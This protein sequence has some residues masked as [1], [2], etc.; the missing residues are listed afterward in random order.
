MRVI[1]LVRENLFLRYVSHRV[2]C[3][4]DQWFVRA[5]GEGA[6]RHV[7]VRLSADEVAASCAEMAA[8]Q[9]SCAAFPP[10]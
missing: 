2:A 8:W 5:G 6:V 4:T 7:T 3:L 10:R 9:A 1:H